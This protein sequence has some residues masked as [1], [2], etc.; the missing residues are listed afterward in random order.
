[1]VKLKV[2]NGQIETKMVS[3]NKV[4]PIYKEI[5]Q[6]I[7]ELLAEFQAE[8]IRMGNSPEQVNVA[9]REML[10]VIVENNDARVKLKLNEKGVVQNE[11]SLT[12]R[13]ACGHEQAS[14]LPACR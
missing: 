8:A 4:F 13:Q 14:S 3:D 12:H 11:K 7:A 6:G 1:M 5:G 2:K 10:S 9:Y